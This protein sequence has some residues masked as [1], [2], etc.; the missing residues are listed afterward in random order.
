MGL[1]LKN[2][3][4]H[5]FVR[6]NVREAMSENWPDRLDELDLIQKSKWLEIRYKNCA[7]LLHNS[8]NVT[9]AILLSH[10]QKFQPPRGVD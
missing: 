7:Q 6:N 10:T 3:Q 1:V 8:F 9:Y 2:W 5:S 4:E